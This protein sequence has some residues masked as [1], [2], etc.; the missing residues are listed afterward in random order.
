MMKCVQVARRV[1]IY[2]HLYETE[3]QMKKK[4]SLFTI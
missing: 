2:T 3:I 1:C 4:Y